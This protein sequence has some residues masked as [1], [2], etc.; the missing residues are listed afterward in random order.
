[1]RCDAMGDIVNKIQKKNRIHGIKGVTLDLTTRSIH[2]WH[3]HMGSA[4]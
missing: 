3:M 1:M 4:L 2:V